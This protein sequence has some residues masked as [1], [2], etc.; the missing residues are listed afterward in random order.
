MLRVFRRSVFLTAGMQRY[1]FTVVTGGGG[2]FSVS[3]GASRDD[4]GLLVCGLVF[5]GRL[6]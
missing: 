1:R 3:C 5:R 6:P 4:W 2:G